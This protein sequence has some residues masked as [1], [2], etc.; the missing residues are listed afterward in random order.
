MRKFYCVVFLTVMLQ[1]GNAWAQTPTTTPGDEILLGVIFGEACMGLVQEVSPYWIFE[2]F[3]GPSSDLEKGFLPKRT[4]M[5]SLEEKTSRP[6]PMSEQEFRDHIA[7]TARIARAESVR[8]ESHAKDQDTTLTAIMQGKNMDEKVLGTG[9][10]R[11]LMDG[12][13]TVMYTQVSKQGKPCGVWET[14]IPWIKFID[15]TK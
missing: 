15:H 13:P 7:E 3:S 8:F 10:V 2:K 5:Q 12:I 1:P 6:A 4:R 14:V 11:L 9:Y